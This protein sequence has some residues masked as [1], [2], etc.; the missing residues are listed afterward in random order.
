MHGGQVHGLAYT[1]LQSV[2]T[3]VLNHAGID[4]VAESRG[5]APAQPPGEGEQCVCMY[6]ICW[7]A[8]MGCQVHVLMQT[9]MTLNSSSWKSFW[10]ILRPVFLVCIYT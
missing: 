8:E 2:A 1:F 9:M 4:L 10:N 7:S 5:E 6:Y 3:H